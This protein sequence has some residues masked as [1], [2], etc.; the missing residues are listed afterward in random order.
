LRGSN[1]VG[2]VWL[3]FR[4]NEHFGHKHASRKLVPDPFVPRS[5]YTQRF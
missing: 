2:G 3:N 4:P 5:P 1:Q